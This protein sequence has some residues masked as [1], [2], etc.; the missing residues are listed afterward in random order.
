MTTD[1]SENGAI[2]NIVS[3]KF[4]WTLRARDYIAECLGLL[5]RAVQ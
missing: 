2:N 3:Y 5:L 1:C 4:L